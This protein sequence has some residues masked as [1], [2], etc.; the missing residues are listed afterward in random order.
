MATQ[1]VNGNRVFANPGI[2]GG[3]FQSANPV[4][5]AMIVTRF[6]NT[7]SIVV[8]SAASAGTSATGVAIPVQMF[9]TPTSSGGFLSSAQLSAGTNYDWIAI[10]VGG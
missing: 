2:D 9:N 3:Q 8:N 10:G 6:Y 7:Q 4:Q 5:N 1:V